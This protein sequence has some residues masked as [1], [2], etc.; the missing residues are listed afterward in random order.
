MKLLKKP[1]ALLTRFGVAALL[2]ALLPLQTTSAAQLAPASV[3]LGSSAPSATTTEA[4]S[5]KTSTTANIGSIG[6]K[7]CAAPSGTC[8]TPTGFSSS[9]ATLTA[10]TPS[11]TSIVDTTAGAPYLSRTAASVTAGSTMTFTLGSVTNPSTVGTSSTGSFYIFITTYTGTDGA[12][13]PIDTTTVAASTANQIVLNATVPPNLT[14]CSYNTG[15]SCSDT[16]T[17]VVNLGV[18]SP[19]ATGSGT[20]EL[21]AST[22][23]NTGY[24]ITVNGT[25]LTSGSN[26]LPAYTTN[27][28]SPSVGTSG[29]GMNLRADTAPAVTGSADVVNGSSPSIGTYGTAT[30]NAGDSATYATAN[31]FVFNAGDIIAYATGPT[32]NN[33]FTAAYIANTGGAQAAGLYTTTLTYICTATF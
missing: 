6:L 10:S 20:S 7:Y 32:N 24:V 3:T 33:T 2:L 28:A 9:S 19:L 22:N 29:F 16:S 12:T 26:T 21:A 1:R 13:G 18:L 31:S 30:Q 23:A 15:G 4:F 27:T 5:I 8:T 11:F 17:S 14:F 25:T